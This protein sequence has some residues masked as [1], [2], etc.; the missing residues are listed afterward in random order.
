MAQAS[1]QQI[2]ALMVGRNL[3]ELF[4]R[5]QRTP[6]EVV[7]ELKDLAGMVK[8]EA[9]SLQLRRGEVLGIA[10]LVGAGRTE[11]LRALFGLDPVR[12]GEIRLGAY[13]GPA[14]PARRWAQ[15]MGFL[16]EDR[17]TE[18]LAQ[19]LDVA[20]NM[21]LS[22]L[23]G[24][25]PAGLVLPGRRGAV[26]N[27]WVEKLGIRCRGWRQAVGELSGGNQQK[28]AVA[29]LLHHN[30]DVLLLDEATRGIDV[31]SKAQVYKL[32]DE[33]ALAGKAV[34]LVSSYLPELLGVSD[35]I[36]VMCRGRLGQARPVGELNEHSLMLEATGG[37]A[38]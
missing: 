25:G 3:T 22:Q 19:G 4:P 17:K 32:I 13:Q 24:F 38:A 20:D 18:G 6:G 1:V 37:E 9:A 34:L 30:V 8:P 28:V 35:R 11:F 2:V 10:G 26:V 29:R 36:A 14:L 15:G 7:L 31:G 5:S 12:R 27:Q 21:T 33:L 16:S 23:R